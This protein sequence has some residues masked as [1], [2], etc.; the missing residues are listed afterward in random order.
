MPMG[1]QGIAMVEH[2]SPRRREVVYEVERLVEVALSQQQ[3]ND[4][5]HHPQEEADKERWGPTPPLRH[6]EQ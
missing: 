2:R 6:Y 4:S 1:E 5:E 3:H